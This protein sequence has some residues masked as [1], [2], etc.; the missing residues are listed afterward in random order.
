[1]RL[2]YRIALR[3]LFLHKGRSIAIG[4]VIFTGA[5]FMTIGNGTVTSMQKGLEA[6][7]VKGT[8][9]DITLLSEERKEDNLNASQEPIP[10]IEKYREVYEVISRENEVEGILPTVWGSAAMLDISMGYDQSNEFDSIGFAGVD[11]EQYK[12]VRGDNIRIIEGEPLKGGERGILINKTLRERIYDMYRMWILPE[13]GSIVKENLTTEA[14]AEY[15]NLRTRNDLVLMGVEGN[16]S[17]SDVRV[18]VKGIFEYRQI[19]DML[20]GL[21]IIDIE[22]AREC[23]GFLATDDTEADISREDQDLLQSVD[24]DPDRFFS[25]DLIFGD[26]SETPEAHDYETI[27]KTSSN[28]RIKTNYD[29]GI[30]TMVQINLKPNANLQAAVNRLNTAFQEASLDSY[31]RA[32][33]W[34]QAWPIFSTFARIFRYALRIFINVIYF[35]AILMIANI[36][37]IAAV[38]RTDEIGTMRTLGAQKGFASGMFMAETSLISLLFGILGIVSGGIAIVLFDVIEIKAKSSFIQFLFGGDAFCPALDINSLIVGMIQL[39]FITAIA[40]GYP[41]LV[42]RRI[43]PMDAIKRN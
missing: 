7:I 31:V 38:E 4:S 42:A 33:S 21:N 35:A 34:K 26:M 32:V 27:L 12:E 29:N 36:L 20:S 23:M 40:M 41:A 24:E 3:N 17:A 13:N 9:G 43:T 39:A 1:M 30:Y 8:V 25:G 11:F 37:S 2:I 14:L 28:E 18:S 6:N 10:L 15:D 5:F 19:N 16:T 22:T